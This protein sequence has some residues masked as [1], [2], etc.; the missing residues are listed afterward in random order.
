MFR[1]TLRVRVR[2]RMGD[3]RIGG[4]RGEN[5]TSE[6]DIGRVRGKAQECEGRDVRVCGQENEGM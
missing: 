4:V 1:I 3:V 6:C 5:V 2:A